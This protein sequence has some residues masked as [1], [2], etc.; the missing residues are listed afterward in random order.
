VTREI[1]VLLAGGT[2]DAR[3]VTTELLARGFRVVWSQATDVPL[4]L[5][6][7][8]KLTCRSGPLTAE[9]F[10]ELARREGIRVLVDVGHP[11]AERL[12]EALRI[13]SAGLGLPLL[14]VGRRPVDFEP[15]VKLARS[16]EEAAR[17]AFDVSGPAFLTVGTRHLDP[18]VA[19]AQARGREFVAR[20]LDCAESRRRV[21]ALGIL[22]PVVFAR[23]PFS[24]EDNLRDFRRF[25]ARVVVMKDSG[26]EGGLPEK[27][28]AA[29]ALDCVVIVVER[30]REIVKPFYSAPELLEGLRRL[31]AVVC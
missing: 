27:L 22:G 29:R 5:P 14:R 6:L 1:P 9:G 18:Y 2:S 30:P 17:A 13:A 25:R 21:H 12:H 24:L 16:H 7:H 11:H 10:A 26:A 20:V 31:A 8:P 4:S 15:W 23:G 19:A 3:F 28:D